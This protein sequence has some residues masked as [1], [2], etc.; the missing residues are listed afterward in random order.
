MNI[1][2]DVHC[3]HCNA[4][5]ARLNTLKLN[6]KAIWWSTELYFTLLWT[7][8]WAGADI[9][10]LWWLTTRTLVLD[11]KGLLTSNITWDWLLGTQG[12]Y[13]A[14]WV[15][16]LFTEYA[17]S[18]Q[19]SRHY[20]Q[21]RVFCLKSSLV[22][23]QSPHAIGPPARH[24]YKN[25]H[26]KDI[27]LT[28]N[29]LIF[30]CLHFIQYSLIIKLLFRWPEVDLIGWHWLQ[31]YDPVVFLLVDDAN[32]CVNREITNHIKSFKKKANLHSI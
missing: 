4:V 29:F 16:K 23:D 21:M 8:P 15:N 31:F 5:C 6:W 10:W 17:R 25:F 2:L 26:I 19:S 1:L 14:L 18:N 7:L 32:K 27:S 30:I 20:S 24:T 11:V 9:D 13:V 3:T 28:R 12:F 22:V